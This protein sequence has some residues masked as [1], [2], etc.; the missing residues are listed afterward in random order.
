MAYE[1]EMKTGAAIARRAG[2]LALKIREGNIGVES[3]SDESPVT[4]ADKA[5]EK[6]IVEELASAFPDDGMLGEEGASKESSNGRRWIIDPIDGTRDFIRGTRAWSVL[7]GLE[8]NGAVVAGHAY[9]PA[10]NEM[11]SAAK[12]EGAFWDGQ[13]MHASGV[14]KKS[15]ALLCVN[16]FSFMSGYPFAKDL[17]AWMAEFWTVR[18]MGG[19]LDAML[20]ATGRADAWLETKAKPWDLA[21]LK[22]IAQEAGCTT[23]D[24][25]GS[26]T[27]YGGNYVICVPALAEQILR[28]VAQN[29]KVEI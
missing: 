12:G 17:V 7:I 16:G 20:V 25:E 23:F 10:L 4:I 29:S 2:E 11:F 22:I 14:T 18:S 15:E 21:P 27:I 1:K 3:K 24:F 13:R 19:C 8:E 28:F 5:C 6:L 26:D 9:F